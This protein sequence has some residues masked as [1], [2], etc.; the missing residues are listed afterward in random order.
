MRAQLLGRSLIC[1]SVAIL[2]TGAVSYAARRRKARVAVLGSLT[3]ANDFVD[4]P[5]IPPD[6]SPDEVLDVAVQYTF[7]ASDP[8]AIDSAYT[9]ALRRHSSS[10]K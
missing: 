5:E 1:V 10:A 4:F 3:S 7:P 8:I 6:A 2:A 9:A